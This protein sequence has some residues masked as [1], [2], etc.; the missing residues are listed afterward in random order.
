LEDQLNDLSVRSITSD[1]LVNTQRKIQEMEKNMDENK[2]EIQKDMNEMKKSIK[3]ILLQRIPKRDM[4]IQEIMKIRRNNGVEIQSHVG[5][6][7]SQLENTNIESQNH[8][9]HSKIHIIE[10][11]MWHQGTTSF[12]RSI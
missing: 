7:L 3:T 1:E 2:E 12:Q 4:E 8:D 5:S 10:V 6:I 11:S 9:Y